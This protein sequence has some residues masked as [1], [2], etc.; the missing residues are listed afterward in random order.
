MTKALFR[1]KNFLDFDVIAF[2]FLFDKYYSIIKQLSLKYLFRDL[3]INYTISYFL[4][5]FNV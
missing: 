2:S 5:I 3:Q 4:S 1:S